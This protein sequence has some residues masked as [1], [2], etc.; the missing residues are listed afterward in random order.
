ME[1][2]FL[3][4]LLFSLDFPPSSVLKLSIHFLKLIDI[5]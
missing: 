2:L 5:K 1:F 3:Q 4:L